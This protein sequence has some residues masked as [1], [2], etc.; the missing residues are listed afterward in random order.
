MPWWGILYII[1][2][3]ILSIAGITEQFRTKQISHGLATLISLIIFCAFVAGYFRA[4]VSASI[5]IWCLPMLILVSIYDWWLS[6][7]DL[8]PGSDNFMKPMPDAK[9]R[10]N[11]MSAMLILV[12]AYIAGLILCYRAYLA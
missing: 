5:G 12:P 6:N 9:S 4:D 7:Y 1:V 8:Q 3:S 11:D 10:L 2:L